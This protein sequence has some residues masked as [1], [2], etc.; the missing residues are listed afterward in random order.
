LC[1]QTSLADASQYL[2]GALDGRAFFRSATILFPSSWKGDCGEV[3]QPANGE[4]ATRADVR[5][6]PPHLLFSDALWTQQSQGC[7]KPGDFISLAYTRLI[8]PAQQPGELGE[9]KKTAFKSIANLFP[10]CGAESFS[11][12]VALAVASTRFALFCSRYARPLI[13]DEERE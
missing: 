8:N 12:G 7:G 10:A 5:I 2:N 9:Q 4:M 6:T 1:F 13:R 3:V 11:L